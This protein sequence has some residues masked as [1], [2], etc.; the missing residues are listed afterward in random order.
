MESRK[1]QLTGGSSYI[2]SLPKWWVE[3]SGLKKNDAVNIVPR[4][5]GSLIL[6]PGNVKRLREKCKVIHISNDAESPW[7]LRILVGTYM[8]GFSEIRIKSRL[9]LQPFMKREI[10][11]FTKIAIGVEIVEERE[12][13][14]IIKDLLNPVEIPI[15]KGLRR[16]YEISTEMHKHALL[17]FQTKDFELVEDVIARDSEVDRLYW[18]IARQYHMIREHIISEEETGMSSSLALHSFLLSRYMERIGD[19]GVR[20]AK[21]IRVLMERGYDDEKA[22]NYIEKAQNYA[23]SIYESSMESFF[24]K[25]LEQANSTIEHVDKLIPMCKD[26]LSFANRTEA[27]FAVSLAYISESIRRVGEYAA[28]IA[29]DTINYIMENKKENKV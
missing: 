7:L 28:D 4:E 17:A 14:V 22:V 5:D 29:E 3:R 23:L 8:A 26:I 20:M 13:E 18:L 10:R 12:N 11:K 27:P 21:S 16:M 6:F 15:L 1:I 24:S 19:H 9:P 25:S 2:V